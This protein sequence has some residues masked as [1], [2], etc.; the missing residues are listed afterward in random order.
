MRE[1]LHIDRPALDVVEW[2]PH[3]DEYGE[4]MR[5]AWRAGFDAGVGEGRAREYEKQAE[6]REI[7]GSRAMFAGLAVGSIGASALALLAWA[8]L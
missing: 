3:D 1:Q 2:R 8:L 4:A 6:E 5:A 7:D